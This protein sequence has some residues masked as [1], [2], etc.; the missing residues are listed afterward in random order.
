M[1]KDLWKDNLEFSE[2]IGAHVAGTPS[3]P[4]SIVH[5][6][7]KN[8]VEEE[9]NEFWNALEDEDLVKMADGAADLIVVVLGTMWAYGIPFDKVWDEVHKTNMAKTTGPIRGDGKRLKPEGWIP[10]DIR[11]ILQNASSEK[12]TEL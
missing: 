8:L 6:L 3:Y 10:P 1:S 12:K 11:G 9:F 7:R 5:T 2:A 4:P